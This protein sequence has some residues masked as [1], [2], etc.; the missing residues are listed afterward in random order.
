MSIQAPMRRLMQRTVRS[1]KV[2][3][4]PLLSL[5]VEILFLI[6][7]KLIWHHDIKRREL[8]TFRFICR[9]FNELFLPIVFAK[10]SAFHSD[11]FLD[12]PLDHVPLLRA[13]IHGSHTFDAIKT[14]DI[15]SLAWLT[16]PVMYTYEEREILPL[17]QRIKQRPIKVLLSIPYGILYPRLVANKCIQIKSQ[18]HFLTTRRLCLPNVRILKW[19]VASDNKREIIKHA[20]TLFSRLPQLTEL[21]LI[22]RYTEAYTTGLPP[23]SKL[24]NL[25]KLTFRIQSQLRPRQASDYHRNLGSLQELL[26]CNPNLTHL[27]IRL[28]DQ[29]DDLD[30][31]GIFSCVP[32][33]KPLILQHLGLSYQFRRGWN[34]ARILPH[35]HWLTSVELFFSNDSRIQETSA[36]FH[37]FWGFLA[38]M[39]I[40]PERIKT[41][42]L[43]QRFF[44][45][46]KRHP[47]LIG[48]TLPDLGNYRNQFMQVLTQH[49]GTLEYLC[50]LIH[51]LVDLLRV[52]ENIRVFL[53]CTRM[54]EMYIY[55]FGA[56]AV[57]S[58]NPC[59]D[60]VSHALH[61][62]TCFSG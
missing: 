13:L 36:E 33:E 8:K 20:V 44:D 15:K 49:A 40:Y 53:Q 38:E 18:L 58:E 17:N 52:P 12:N 25:R 56:R 3:Q 10:F 11:W 37:D 4:S 42:D 34:A 50:V 30:L 6:R 2:T 57:L 51:Q 16:L 41:S 22:I 1:S 14:L 62:E 9:M 61:F 19:L 27:T 46:L 23:L 7:D 54:Q 47:N 24:N 28:D 45:Y 31:V 35:I 5:P 32:T 29:I 21:K 43:D 39:N 26:A 60:G 48:L 59:G 55:R